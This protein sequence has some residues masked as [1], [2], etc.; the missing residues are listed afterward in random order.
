MKLTEEKCR[1]VTAGETPLSSRDAVELGQ[2][3]PEW[4]IY[5]K[6]IQRE[7]QFKDFK[8]SIEFA[9][10]VAGLAEE[11]NHH[12][13][14]CIFYNKVKLVLSTHKIDGLSRNDFILAAK[15]D[16]LV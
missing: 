6:S 16:W 13:D 5:D 8:R 9:N 12:P 2:Q 4:T 10:K 3:I 1:P 14:I 7:F 11:Q 15:I